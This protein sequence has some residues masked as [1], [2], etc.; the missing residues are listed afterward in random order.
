MEHHDCKP[1]MEERPTDDT[2]WTCPDCGDRWEVEPLEPIDPAP[3]YTFH[4]EGGGYAGPTHAR[5]V[6]RGE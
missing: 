5:W 4:P 1:P 6:R 3:R 2:W